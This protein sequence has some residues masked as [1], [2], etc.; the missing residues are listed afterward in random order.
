MKPFLSC[1]LLARQRS[2]PHMHG[3][4][5]RRISQKGTHGGHLGFDR[6]TRT[7]SCTISPPSPPRRRNV[8]FAERPLLEVRFVRPPPLASAHVKR[9]R[10]RERECGRERQKKRGGRGVGEGEP[11]RERER[12]ML[13]SPPE[14]TPSAFGGSAREASRTDPPRNGFMLRR[15]HPRPRH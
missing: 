5:L 9:E 12:D 3:A 14:P 2:G 11:E 4:Y 15:A 13:H 10:E 7:D 6:Y 8:H 1:P